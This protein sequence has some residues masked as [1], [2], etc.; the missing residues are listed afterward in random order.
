METAE[1]PDQVSTVTGKKLAR[2]IRKVEAPREEVKAK[3]AIGRYP[4]RYASPVTTVTPGVVHSSQLPR[5]AS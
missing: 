5:L 2:A 3:K 1:T 4:A